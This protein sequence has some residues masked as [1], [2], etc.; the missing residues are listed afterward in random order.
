[1]MIPA[2]INDRGIVTI[3]IKTERKLPRNRKMTA[4]T[5]RTAWPSDQ[6]D[7][8]DRGLDEPGR[9]V[10]DLHLDRGRQV[11]LDLG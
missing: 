6:L 9:I 4:T 2:P 3:G 7:L 1:M 10:G 8:V 5:I 11:A